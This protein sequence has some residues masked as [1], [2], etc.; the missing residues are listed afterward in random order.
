M[1]CETGI[2]PGAIVTRMSSIADRVRDHSHALGAVPRRGASR[3]AV[4]AFEA[5]HRLR[6]PPPMAEFYLALDGL[7]GDV[8]DLGLHAL[9]LWPLTELTRVSEGIA[10]CRGTPDYGP[11]LRTLPDAD[12]YLAFG[13]AMCW[14]HVLAARLTPE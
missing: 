7:E 14:S 13:D 1:R 10:E 2:P 9:E 4:A 12:Q 3:G 11:I 6:L 5:A 8:P